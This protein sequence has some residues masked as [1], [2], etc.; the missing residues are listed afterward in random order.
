MKFPVTLKIFDWIALIFSLSVFT[1]FTLFG[2]NRGGD[3]I[4]LMVETHDGSA[5]YPLSE[6]KT[7]TVSG[8]VGESVIDIKDGEARFTHS[9]C[10]DEICVQAGGISHA[11]EWAACL[12]NQVIISTRGAN[13][14]SEVPDAY[15]Y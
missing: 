6:D 2:W 5:L 1:A 4:Y 7:F 3:T 15:L 9:D 8:P 14:K 13:E 10:P 12:P 11:G